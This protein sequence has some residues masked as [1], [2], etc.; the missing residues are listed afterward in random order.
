LLSEHLPKAEAGS[1]ETVSIVDHVARIGSYKAVPG[2]PLV[3]LVTRA[4]A[5]VLAPWH[6]FVAMVSPVIVLIVTGVLV[7]TLVL[8]R[9]TRDV[10]A[11]TQALAQTNARFDAP[12][13]ACRKAPACSM[14]RSAW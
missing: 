7:G 6:E 5:D 4:R 13:A 10:I 3:V 12:C 9:R 2:L 8:L 14:P 1:Y 11:K